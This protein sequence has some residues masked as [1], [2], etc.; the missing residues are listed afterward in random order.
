M[1]YPVFLILG[2]LITSAIAVALAGPLSALCVI[3]FWVAHYFF[4]DWRHK[5]ASLTSMSDSELSDV[6]DWWVGG[7]P[8]GRNKPDLSRVRERNNPEELA[9][10]LKRIVEILDEKIKREQKYSLDTSHNEQKRQQYANELQRLTN[11]S[12]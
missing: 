2:L 8:F 3:G 1:S 10:T 5:N 6:L 7:G 9:T 4:L 11:S 12:G